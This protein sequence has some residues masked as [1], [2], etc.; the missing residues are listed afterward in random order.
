VLARARG[1]TLPQHLATCWPHTETLRFLGA[2]SCCSLGSSQGGSDQ[3]KLTFCVVLCGSS[4]TLSLQ[5]GRASSSSLS[6]QQTKL[7]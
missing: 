6:S 2:R 4:V 5:P 7:H 3:G 1:H